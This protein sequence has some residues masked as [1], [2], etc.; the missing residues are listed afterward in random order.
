MFER[1]EKAFTPL[2]RLL[3]LWLALRPG[4]DRGGREGVRWVRG[5]TEDPARN[6][7]EQRLDTLPLSPQSPASAFREQLQEMAEI[8]ELEGRDL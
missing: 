4:W 5:P 1:R 7:W 6:N 8:P 3:G 2:G